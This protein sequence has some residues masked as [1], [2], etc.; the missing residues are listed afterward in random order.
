[1]GRKVSLLKKFNPGGFPT[2]MD[3]ILRTGDRKPILIEDEQL[4]YEVILGGYMLPGGNVILLH[5]GRPRYRR[6]RNPP[7]DLNLS[8]CLLQDLMN[9]LLD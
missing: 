7:P 8:S 5:E 6:G 2:G 1:M 4:V 9:N 3:V